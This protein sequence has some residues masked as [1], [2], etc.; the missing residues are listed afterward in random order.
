MWLILIVDW[1]PMVWI[2]KKMMSDRSTHA[3]P[4]A[5]FPFCHMVEFV[6]GFPLPLARAGHL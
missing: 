5:S 6:W 1:W 2:D 3:L 4:L